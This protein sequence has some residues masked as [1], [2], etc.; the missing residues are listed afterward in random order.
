MALTGRVDH[1]VKPRSTRQSQ[2]P[3]NRALQGRDEWDV[4]AGWRASGLYP[5]NPDKVLTAIPKPV[6]EP[7]VPVLK[8]TEIDLY[9]QD[10]I[11]Q[12]PTSPT[13]LTALHVRLREDACANDDVSKQR[14]L[15]HIQK[16][17]NAAQIGFAERSIQRDQIQFLREMNNEGKVRRSTKS[18]QLG[19]A[20]VMSYE[21]LEEAREKR[22]AKDAAKAKG[23]GTRGRKRKNPATAGIESWPSAKFSRGGEAPESMRTP[24]TGLVQGQIAP[25]ARMR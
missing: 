20:K 24:G 13:S 17:A 7:A 14:L 21:D 8:T 5:F 11:V 25:V 9:P 1:V 10:E 18:L 19:K 16:F 15:R 12:T 4:L 23:K 6:A 3:G 2:S 22:A